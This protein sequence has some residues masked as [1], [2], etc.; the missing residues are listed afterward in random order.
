MERVEVRAAEVRAAAAEVACEKELLGQTAQQWSNKHEEVKEVFERANA[1]QMR[2]QLILEAKEQKLERARVQHIREAA[3]THEESGVLRQREY[4]LRQQAREE[5]EAMQA[6]TE[7]LRQRH[8]E[9]AD[10]V[11]TSDYGGGTGGGAG[12]GSFPAR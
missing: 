1:T 6:A 8:Q 10:E 9:E 4:T 5:E 2:E 7:Q 3:R 11:R 12:G